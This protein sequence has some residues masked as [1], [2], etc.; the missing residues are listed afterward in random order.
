MPAPQVVRPVMVREQIHAR[1]RVVHIGTLAIHEV[2][3]CSS[4][5]RSRHSCRMSHDGRWKVHASCEE[6]PSVREA[7]SRSLTILDDQ[8][9]EMSSMVGAAMS[10]ASGALLGADLNRAE[11]VIA[12]DRVID[13]LEEHLDAKIVAMLAQQSPVATDL[14][15]LIT[16]LRMSSTLERMGDL[17]RHIAQL[18]R[19]RFPAP[20][21][22]PSMQDLFRE[23]A[24][25]DEHLADLARRMIRDR[26]LGLAQ[27]IITDDD[28]VDA[29]HRE[30]FRR[31]TSPDWSSSSE[32]IVDVTLCSRYLERFGDHAV[33]LAH[34][35]EYL[36]TG[37]TSN[38]R[39]SAWT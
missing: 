22:P 2:S 26:D 18:A 32:V 25:A 35:M 12:A 10:N 5:I 13:D 21:I 20:A 31:V 16:G 34:R 29:M 17:A 6:G 9:V 28:A 19:L 33:S 24:L 1:T 11:A 37:D 30:V 3:G 4:P 38:G 39:H 8:L 27:Q 23:M 36:V 15:A 7:F 14:R